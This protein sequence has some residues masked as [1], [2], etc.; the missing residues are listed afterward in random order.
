M[1][2]QHHKDHIDGYVTAREDRQSALASRSSNAPNAAPKLRPV[3]FERQHAGARWHG[4]SVNKI[5]SRLRLRSDSYLSQHPGVP[6]KPWERGDLH[7]YG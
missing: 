4:F 1:R 5:L 6:R 7:A 2:L 3:T